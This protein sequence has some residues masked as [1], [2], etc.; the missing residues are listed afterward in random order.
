MKTKKQLGIFSAL[1]VAM[2]ATIGTGIV[3]TQGSILTTTGS[4]LISLIGWVIAGLLIVPQMMVQGEMV[5]AY[6]DA[7]GPYVFY[8]KARLKSMSFMYGWSYAIWGWPFSIAFRGYI[9]FTFLNFFIGS[10]IGYAPFDAWTLRAFTALTIIVFGAINYFSVKIGTIVNNFLSIGKL[11]LMFL[12]IT[13]AFLGFNGG[14]FSGE[15]AKKVIG[16]G[17]IVLIW[18]KGIMLSVALAIWSYNGINTIAY[19]APEF[20]NARRNLPIIMIGGA[21]III[22]I[23]ALFVIAIGGLLSANDAINQGIKPDNIVLEALKTL[24]FKWVTSTLIF[25]LFILSLST[26]FTFTKVAPRLPYAMAQDGLFFKSFAKINKYNTP[27]IA[28]IF[29]TLFA[30]LLSFIPYPIEFIVVFFTFGTAI[31]NFMISLTILRC[32]KNADYKPI[33]RIK[34]RKLVLTLTIL[35]CTFI[36]GSGLYTAITHINKEWWFIFAPFSSL[37][38]IFSAFPVYAIWQKIKNRKVARMQTSLAINEVKK[39]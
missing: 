4:V 27:G 29:N 36:A 17:N 25:L 2:G 5:S 7:G 30:A 12:I 8:K 1:F 33:Y 39:L 31:N 26:V 35:S 34:N 11:G 10:I 15:I 6:P 16:D 22:A 13:V 38:I 19:M 24:N 14:N 23:Y 18:F 32:Q 9:T 28:I 21:L 20:K 3:V 37:V